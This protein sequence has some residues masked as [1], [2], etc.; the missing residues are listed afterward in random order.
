MVFPLIHQILDFERQAA[1]VSGR[2]RAAVKTWYNRKPVS[3]AVE[4]AFVE[5]I[6]TELVSNDYS[7]MCSVLIYDIYEMACSTIIGWSVMGDRRCALPT[8]AHRLLL[9]RHFEIESRAGHREIRSLPLWPREE[10]E[11][12]CCAKPDDEDKELPNY[13][14]AWWKM[15]VPPVVDIRRI[16]SAF[17]LDEYQMRGLQPQPYPADDLLAHLE[18]MLSCTKSMLKVVDRQMVDDQNILTKLERRTWIIENMA[19]ICEAY[20]LEIEGGDGED[21]LNGLFAV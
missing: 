11:R 14:Y 7:N 19:Q 16:F 17:D 6:E 5:G 12:L 1:Y 3:K 2:L 8:F 4:Q 10:A 9:Q 21:L 15:E 13:T 18:S 20:G